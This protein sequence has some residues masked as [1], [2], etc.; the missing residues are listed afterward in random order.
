VRARVPATVAER[1]RPFELDGRSPPEES[2][3]PQAP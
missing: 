2:P 1:L 3:D